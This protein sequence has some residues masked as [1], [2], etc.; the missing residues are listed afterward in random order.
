MYFHRANA[1]GLG[2]H[3]RDVMSIL[4][5][6]GAPTEAAYPFGS[7]HAPDADVIREAGEYKV[8]EYAQVKTIEAVKLAL[9]EDGPC[10]IAFPV[11]NHGTRMWFQRPGE[12]RQGG[13]AMTLVGYNAEGF[14]I[15]N[16]WGASWGDGGHC[17]YPYS[18]F[19]AHWD[20]W[21]AVDQEGSRRPPPP[22]R[23]LP[24]CA[25]V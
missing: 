2:M 17:V 13:H 14:I 6:I 16:S 25:I 8:K 9:A 11:Y 19:G 21:T 15:R 24:C 4:Y 23:R 18:D 3:G 22:K 12:E 7:D 1:P 20:I 10:Y 5:K